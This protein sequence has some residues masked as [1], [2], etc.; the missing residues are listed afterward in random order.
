MRF[1]IMRLSLKGAIVYFTHR[2]GRCCSDSWVYSPTAGHCSW[3]DSCR[4]PSS[5]LRKRKKEITLCGAKQAKLSWRH[6]WHH[7]LRFACFVSLVDI[8]SSFY[9]KSTKCCRQCWKPMLNQETK[10]QAML[11]HGLVSI[12]H[13]GQHAYTMK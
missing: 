2:E 12:K 13:N 10:R 6:K 4:Q 3:T 7:I 9:G 1:G 8:D 11:F 5:P